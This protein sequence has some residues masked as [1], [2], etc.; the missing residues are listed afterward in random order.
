MPVGLPT[1]AAEKAFRQLA[2]PQLQTGIRVKNKR[3][4][5]FLTTLGDRTDTYTASEGGSDTSQGFTKPTAAVV[6]LYEQHHSMEMLVGVTEVE[7]ASPLE[8]TPGS[9]AL[10]EWRLDGLGLEALA[11]RLPV[12]KGGR[13]H[14]GL[15]H[16]Q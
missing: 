15:G 8:W 5:R 13:T 11:D 3:T 9:P 1:P 16:Y 2:L 14:E 12:S 6:V 4:Q 7:K 10:A